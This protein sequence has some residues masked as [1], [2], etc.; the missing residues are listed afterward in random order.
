MSDREEFEKWYSQLN[1]V[2]CY[3]AECH[4]NIANNAWQAATKS[5]EAKI[6]AQAKQI[7]QM[8]Y[9]LENCKLAAEWLLIISQPDKEMYK[10]EIQ[11]SANLT[12]SRINKALASLGEHK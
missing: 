5:S 9:E 1:D 3:G 12:I 4:K 10:H 7:E 8:K 11:A 2:E 6:E